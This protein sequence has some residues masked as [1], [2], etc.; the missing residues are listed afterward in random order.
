MTTVAAFLI[1]CQLSTAGSR[2][3]ELLRTWKAICW[4]ES[5]GDPRAVNRSE[6]AVGIGQI[7]P[8]YV[9]DANR[10]AGR[11]QFTLADRLDPL[12][13]FAMFRTVVLHYA[14]KG[15][16][17]EWSRI[18]NGGAKGAKNSSTFGYARDVLRIMREQG[19]R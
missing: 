12:Q 19:K 8:I 7:R 17:W 5:R 16:A 14:P 6:N 3:A 18:H 9:R 15:G 1:A 11:E 10:I 4:K 2:D 13:S